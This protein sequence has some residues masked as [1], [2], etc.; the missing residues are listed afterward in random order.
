[1]PSDTRQ[2]EEVAIEVDGGH[3][4]GTLNI[5][6]DAQGIVIFSH[7]SGSSRFSPR[8]R[9]VATR[10]QQA[11]LATL[12][13]DLRTATEEIVDNETGQLR[14]NI[15]FLG[16]RLSTVTDW[17]LQHPGVRRLKI[18]YFGAST[19]AAAALVAASERDDIAAIVSRG[20]RPDL[21]GNAL[22]RVH[23]PTLL[24]VGSNDR[25]VLALNRNASA[26]LGRECKLETV[27]GA[28]HL[29]EEPGALEQV[30]ER[31]TEW[32]LRWLPYAENRRIM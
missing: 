22:E 3:V 29:F 23:S 16:R 25:D 30:A 1:M 24:L 20:G 31:A 2:S 5:A 21:A 18:G 7:G 13:V 11:H 9:A 19:G 4:G 17:A 28:T 32:F 6:S 15:P 10:L 8:N 27:Q 12:L 26:R 14:F